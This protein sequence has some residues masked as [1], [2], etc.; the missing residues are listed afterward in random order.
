MISDSM[1][2]V[3]QYS[4]VSVEIGEGLETCTD[5]DHAWTITSTTWEHL[6]SRWMGVD[7]EPLRKVKLD[8]DRQVVLENRGY[9]SATW[10]TLRSLQKVHG[11][12]EIWDCTCVTTPSFLSQIGPPAGRSTDTTATEKSMDTHK[13]VVIIWDGLDVEE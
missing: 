9:R 11:S 4:G 5:L 6:K 12:E 10:H 7:E 2:T 13:P 1:R 8:C 3:E